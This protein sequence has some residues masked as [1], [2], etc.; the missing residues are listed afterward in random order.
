[1]Q[2]A[3]DITI[4]GAG[5]TGL[6]AAF[7]AG[8]RGAS[9][10]LIDNLDQVGGQLTALYPEKYIFDVAGFPKIL[11]KDLVKGM[12][13]QGLQWKGPVH[14]A[15]RV[16]GLRR[17]QENGKP[18][19]TVVTDKDE[20]PGRTVLIAGGLGAFTPRKLPLKDADHWVG[21]GLHDRVLN[22]QEFAGKRILIVGG[23]DSAFDWAVNLQGIAKFIVVSHRRG[24]VRAPDA[25]VD[26]VHALAAAGKMELRTF[27]ELRAIT[28][29]KRIE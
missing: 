21:K 27:W 17:A 3:K 6:F 19:F 4:I 16:S 12:A 18:M 1:M 7:Y 8:M 20:Y 5:P 9:H 11:A 24:A 26:Q 13:E 15:Q 22:P 28:G 23:G 2:D 25:T 29:G 14:L 10:C